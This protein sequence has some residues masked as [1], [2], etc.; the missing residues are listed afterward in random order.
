MT[1]SR[2][3]GPSWPADSRQ[4]SHRP[5]ANSRAKTMLL[6]GENRPP[7]SNHGHITN[8]LGSEACRVAAEGSPIKPDHDRVTAASTSGGNSAASV[9]PVTRRR[10]HSRCFQGIN[11]KVLRQERYP[12]HRE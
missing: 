3:R 4:A 1:S 2:G 8:L 6:S 9:I 5:G 11:P 12:E 10:A 7:R